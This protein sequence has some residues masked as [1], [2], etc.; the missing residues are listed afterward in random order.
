MKVF[1]SI[2]ITLLLVC[3]GLNFSLLESGERSHNT[4]QARNPGI[5]ELKNDYSDFSE[6]EKI[7]KSVERFMRMWVVKGMSIAIVKNDKL[8]FAKGYGF[9]DVENKIQVTPSNIFRIASASKLVTATA[10]MKLCE[11]GKL[12]LDDKVFGPAG[13]FNEP[14][15]L[16]Y[17]D[18][19]LEM[20]TIKNLLNHSGGWSQRFGDPMFNSL[21]I[22]KKVGDK[23]P[24][25]IDTYIK[26]ILARDLQFTPGTASC[27]S[28]MGYA[29]LSKIIE[30]VSGM[31]YEAYVKI[32]LLK[33]I[34]I[35][36]MHIG[37]TL[38]VNRFYNEVK[39]YE[40]EG[41]KMV[42]SCFGDGHLV[43]KSDG[44][45]NI[46]LLSSAGGWV[47]SAPEL[48]K[49]VTAIDG[50]SSNQLLSKESISEMTHYD[51]IKGPLGWKSVS[52]NGTWW[53][54]GSMPGTSA[55]IKRMADGTEWVVIMNTSSW[56][57]PFFPRYV[58]AMLTHILEKN[59]AWPD[60][61]LFDYMH[62]NNN[63]MLASRK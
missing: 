39:Y 47:V 13:I 29:I 54:T 30:K 12:H 46:E 21:G 35:T 8:V 25:T 37:H 23:A 28:N 60:H 49:F 32:H 58:D 15:Y 2:V 20:I 53:R 36:D 33:P 22:A 3:D 16:H 61:N 6:S 5:I 41:S 63:R 40:Q 24:A 57:G 9:A 14:Q 11:D 18:K 51:P 43:K 48:A 55:V 38:S 56:K 44:G 4:S 7:D 50:T 10:V 42:P 52:T 26:F 17:K 45:N 34:G 62:R 27:Y 59:I 1:I 19:R 31:P